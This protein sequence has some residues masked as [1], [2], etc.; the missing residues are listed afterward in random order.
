MPKRTDYLSWDEYFMAVA[1]LSSKR[2]K[3]PSTQVGAC[4]VNSSNKII[5]IGYNG[6][7]NGCNDDIMP[8]EKDNINELDNKYLYVCHAELNAILNR[9]VLDSVN[10]RIY[11]ALFPCSECAKVIIQAGIKE[12]IYMNDTKSHK[13]EYQ[14][15]R[16]LFRISNV[17][18][19]K[20]ETNRQS[21]L[22]TFMN[23]D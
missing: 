2:S 13:P 15:S 9:N 5:G 10:C 6:M 11:V 18:I 8:W 23:N 7:P 3:D 16:R 17:N 22:L 19:R 1:I 4:I 21:I 12:V 20:F 14:A